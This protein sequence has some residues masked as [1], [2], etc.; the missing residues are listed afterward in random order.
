[1]DF[2]KALLMNQIIRFEIQYPKG[3]TVL[4]EDEWQKRMPKKV[5]RSRKRRNVR[6][7][8]CVLN[9]VEKIVVKLAQIIKRM[10]YSKGRS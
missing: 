1:M 6:S 4:D 3:W 2:L 8:L 7:N 9:F 10:D 5:M